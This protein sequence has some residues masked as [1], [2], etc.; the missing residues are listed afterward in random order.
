MADE[1][2][3][4][5]IIIGS[6]PAGST[7][8]IYT[9]RALLRT[10]VIAGGF[11][12][13][14]LTLTTEVENFPGFPEGILGP[15][16]M[17]NMLK[18]AQ[19]F[20]AEVVFRDAIA[21]DFS[22]RPFIIR[23]EDAVYNGRSVIIATG[24]SARSLGLESEARLRGRGV[25]FC[26]I[27]DAPFY[28]GKKAV[29]VGG[30]NTALEEALALS[31]FAE[32]VT[33]VH[34]RDE[35]RAARILQEKAFKDDKITFVWDTVVREI[36]GEDKVKGVRL[37]NVK[38]GKES[39]LATDAVFVAIGYKPN[40][41]LFRGEIELDE[42]GYVKVYDETKTSVEGVFVAGDVGDRRYRQAVT[43]A[44]SGCKAAIDAEKYLESQ[45]TQLGR[46]SF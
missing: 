41:D 36:I 17:D 8:A 10:L 24:A 6:G 9:S 18:Q 32:R 11:W 21:V 14:Q 20:G 34:R 23:V 26:A 15:D 42:E 3:Y 13:G 29:V 45:G 28:A 27:C 2:L 38:T 19:R 40:T 44:A 7:A 25:S 16:L 37:K 4:D 30:G 5:M 33:I 1:G 31:K 43:A 22:K 35:L 12:G 39:Y 46:H